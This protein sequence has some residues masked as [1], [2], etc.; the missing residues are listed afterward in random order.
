MAGEVNNCLYLCLRPPKG[1]WLRPAH[2][3]PLAAHTLSLRHGWG[4]IGL[5]TGR[6]GGVRAPFLDPNPFWAHV[7][8]TP[9]GP[10]GTMT[11]H[12]RR[13][14]RKNFFAPKMQTSK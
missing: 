1:G 5:R 9:D 4:E 3:Q 2:V 7:T 8:G 14:A 6:E 13:E 10:T 11:H 12:L